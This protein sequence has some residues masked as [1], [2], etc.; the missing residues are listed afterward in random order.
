MKD[1]LA[2]AEAAR[3]R[4]GREL[5]VWLLVDDGAVQQELSSR[6][7]STVAVP[8]YIHRFPS[9]TMGSQTSLR[10]SRRGI[11]RHPCL[12]RRASV[13]LRRPVKEPSIP[14]ELPTWWRLTPALPSSPA[15]RTAPKLGAPQ[16]IDPGLGDRQVQDP[17]FGPGERCQEEQHQ[18]ERSVQPKPPSLP[19]HRP[20]Q[21][22]GPGYE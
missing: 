16:D 21:R 1:A 19:N 18:I 15:A 13:P 17:P 20:R 11:P 8:S 5:G 7:T 9:R 3:F 2:L 14:P 22:R 12:H 6:H 10:N 4:R